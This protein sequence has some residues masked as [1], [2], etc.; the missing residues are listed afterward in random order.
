MSLY[1]YCFDIGANVSA[2][3]SL[4]VPSLVCTAVVVNLVAFL[5]YTGVEFNTRVNK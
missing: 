5:C 2:T 1:V 3:C 4:F